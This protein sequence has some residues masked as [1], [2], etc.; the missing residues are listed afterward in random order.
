MAAIIT[1]DGTYDQFSM[2]VENDFSVTKIV[3]LDR[4]MY[5]GD[6]VHFIIECIVD[7][8]GQNLEPF[9]RI[10]IE[11]NLLIEE[12]NMVNFS[13]QPKVLIDHLTNANSIGSSSGISFTDTPYG[14]GAVF[15]RTDESRIE[16]PFP[17][18]LPH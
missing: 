18:P 7:P 13:V 2:S 6:S 3:E 17:D 14:T 16:L 9:E 10:I 11:R 12:N 5:Y 15:E 4:Q 8:T 1:V